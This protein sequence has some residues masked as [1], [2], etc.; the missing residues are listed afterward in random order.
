MQSNLMQ[1]TISCAHA[2]SVLVLNIQRSSENS[3]CFMVSRSAMLCPPSLISLIL[4]TVPLQI[5]YAPHSAE[6]NSHK[7]RA[8]RELCAVM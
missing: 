2:A 7:D 5:E 6:L 3:R 1:N 8:E 4:A